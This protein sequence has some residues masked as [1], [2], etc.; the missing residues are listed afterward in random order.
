MALGIAAAISVDSYGY[1]SE[2]YV[3]WIGYD[4]QTRGFWSAVW[5]ET[6][7]LFKGD[8]KAAVIALSGAIAC[9]P[10][11]PEVLFASAGI[12]S[13]YAAFEPYF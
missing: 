12:G 4:G 8:A 2:N 3:N 10:A 1:W 6:K 9:G 7:R 11:A 13:V 5:A